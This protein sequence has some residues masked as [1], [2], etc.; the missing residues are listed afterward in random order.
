MSN[1]LDTIHNWWY[2]ISGQKEQDIKKQQSRNAINFVID[3]YN[4]PGFRE[5]FK[6]VP[7]YVRNYF[8]DS[9]YCK[10]PDNIP[11]DYIYGAKLD[12]FTLITH[13][14]SP[15]EG[16]YTKNNEVYID[17]TEYTP[18][19]PTFD[20]GGTAAHEVAHA[21]HNNIK[22]TK[23]YKYIHTPYFLTNEY[24]NIFPHFRDSQ[25]YQRV[26]Y[27]LDDKK[28]REQYEQHPEVVY[29]VSSVTHDALP[30]ESYAD[31]MAFREALNRFNIYD[32]RK[33]NN[34]FTKEHLNK[35]KKLNKH[36]R[37]FD[38]F[39]DEQI[40]QMM[41]DVAQNNQN[42]S[43]RLLYAKSGTKLNPIEKFRKGRKVKIILPN[44]YTVTKGK[45]SK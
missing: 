34:L 1:I 36:L 16:S 10:F 25:S 35:W 41:N 38:N 32:S 2:N 43:E 14:N 39:T 22:L 8:A 26:L 20:Y 9:R 15:E 27:H 44:G 18:D 12:P 33:A 17:N 3:Y 24:A 21:F 5:R 30:E 31:L 28:L 45:L 7:Y 40:I 11:K 42:N 23:K 37:L 19:Y 29:D 6:N 4:S 13:Y